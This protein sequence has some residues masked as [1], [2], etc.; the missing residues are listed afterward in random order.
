MHADFVD[1]KIRD[2]TWMKAF[3]RLIFVI[4]PMIPNANFEHDK[5]WAVLIVDTVNTVF[6]AIFIYDGVIKH[7]GG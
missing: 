1:E 3:V 5:V 7:F 6:T 2:R 4:I